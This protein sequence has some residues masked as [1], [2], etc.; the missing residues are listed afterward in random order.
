M[1]ITKKPMAQKV[2]PPEKM[3]AADAVVKGAHE[4][5]AGALAKNNELVKSTYE[6]EKGRNNHQLLHMLAGDVVS[7]EESL[8]VLLKAGANINTPDHLPECG[9]TLLN[10]CAAKNLK[11]LA[12]KVIAS[13]ADLEVEGC[14]SAVLS[15]LDNGNTEM[16]RFLIERGAAVDLYAAAGTG[17]IDALAEFFDNSYN[18]R[19]SEDDIVEFGTRRLTVAL[20]KPYMI[21]CKNGQLEA[22][23]FLM[24][25]GADI[26]LF[27]LDNEDEDSLE[28]SGLHWAA[29]YGHYEL[30]KFLINYGAKIHSKDTRFQKTPA[31]WAEEAGHEQIHKYIAYLEKV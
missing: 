25:R 29:K 10:L 18:L 16:A 14:E 17:Q 4:D 23:F 3:S 7:P 20:V 28:A 11:E 5:L 1:G 13:G 26:N 9:M 31:Q 2:I 12:E 6:N 15:A 8:S 22:V 27:V 30:V 21:A 24:K 19:L